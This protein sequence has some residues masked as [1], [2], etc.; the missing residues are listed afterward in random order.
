MR[1]GI[2]AYFDGLA[3][4]RRRVALIGIAVALAFLGGEFLSHQPAVRAV[5]NDPK[6]FG[7]EGPEQ[8]SR[9]I[10]L[11]YVGHVD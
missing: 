1:H 6:R 5:L 9:R 11:E 8:Y 3:R 10:L 2:D 7:F 4:D